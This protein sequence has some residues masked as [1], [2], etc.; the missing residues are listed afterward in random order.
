MRQILQSLMHTLF[1]PFC[2]CCRQPLEKELSLLCSKCL[3]TLQPGFDE[4]IPHLN[5]L[6]CCFDPCPAALFLA[7]TAE[8]P[9]LLAPLIV[10]RWYELDYPLPDYVAPTAEDWFSIK[11]NSPLAQETARLLDVPFLPLKL[12]RALLKNPYVDLEQNSCNNCYKAIR[13]EYNAVNSSILLIHTHYITGHAL[14]Q[15]ARALRKQGAREILAL[16]A[17]GPVR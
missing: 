10:K 3:G 17:I 16:A 4:T 14:S 13:R 1:P 6:S 12:D 8:S 2:A 11:K 5:R 7:N 15:T 9:K